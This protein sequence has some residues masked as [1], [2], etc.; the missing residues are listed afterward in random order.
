MT[1]TKRLRARLDKMVALTPIRISPEVTAAW[2]HLRAAVDEMFG[3]DMKVNTWHRRSIDRDEWMRRCAEGAPT[4]ADTERLA[5]L[6]AEA[7]M[8]MGMSALTY[9]AAGH[10]FNVEF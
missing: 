9:V 8:T 5:L 7:L 6:P 1:T 4:E 3:I 2:S 10:R